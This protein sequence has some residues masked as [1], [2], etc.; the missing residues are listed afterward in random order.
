[1]K[2]NLLP[3]ED[4]KFMLCLAIE[5]LE[6]QIKEILQEKG[7]NVKFEKRLINLQSLKLKLVKEGFI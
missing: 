5:Q 3:N 2:E 6:A 4:E 7:T 1:M